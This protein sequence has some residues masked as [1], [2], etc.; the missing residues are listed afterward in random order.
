MMAFEDRATQ[1]IQLGATGQTL[2]SLAITIPDM[3]PAFE[4]VCKATLWALD[5]FRPAQVTDDLVTFR[6]INQLLEV[7]HANRVPSHFLFDEGGFP[8]PP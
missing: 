4:D 7:D 3:M 2:I 8:S 1:A 5:A 6:I